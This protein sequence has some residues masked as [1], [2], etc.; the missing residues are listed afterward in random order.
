MRKIIIIITSFITI[1]CLIFTLFLTFQYL[2]IDNTK[3]INTTIKKAK[4]E[5]KKLSD[6]VEKEKSELET[7]KN[8]N[9]EKV[10]V[11]EVWEKELQKVKGN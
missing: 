6:K 3:T 9:Q 2:N 7:I 4:N 1:C 10:G 11:L 8:D 5:V